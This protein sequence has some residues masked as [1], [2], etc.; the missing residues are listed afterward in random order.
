MIEE[1]GLEVITQYGFPVFVCLWFMLR[2]EKI[3]KSNTAALVL[4]GD[5][6]N[7]CPSARPVS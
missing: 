3:I 2:T 4:V 7:H 1:L 5:R 6:I